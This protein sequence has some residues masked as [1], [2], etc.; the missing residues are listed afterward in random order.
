MDVRKSKKSL[1]VLGLIF[2]L[3]LF[4]SG[5]A[6]SQ[7]LAEVQDLANQAMA[8]AEA[9][10]IDSSH[11][12][13]AAEASA[14]SAAKDAGRAEAAAVRAERAAAKSEAMAE[15]SENIFMQKMKK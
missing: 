14:A 13:A 5:C 2:C 10:R 3:G 11:Q 7:Q 6:T 8:E 1:F 12:A 15:K 9:A 4:V